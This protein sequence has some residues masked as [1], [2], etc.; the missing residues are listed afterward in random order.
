VKKLLKKEKS[1]KLKQ[2]LTFR[3]REKALPLAMVD[4]FI[5]MVVGKSGVLA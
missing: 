3:S 2:T 4:I 5:V 1:R